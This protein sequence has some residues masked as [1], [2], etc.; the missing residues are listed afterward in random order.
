VI[1]GVA[2]L[3]SL[4][5]GAWFQS[6]ADGDCGGEPNRSSCA[7]DKTSKER[8]WPVY[9]PVAGP[10]IAMGTGSRDAGV[11]GTWA[12]F[13]AAE[14]AG[15]IMVIG[16]IVSPKAD[17]VRDIAVTSSVRFVPMVRQGAAVALIVGDL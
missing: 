11:V 7:G 12:A 15:A 17:I 6:L 10:F 13:G 1:F 16:G 14:L 9:I 8:Y 5:T 4:A 2:Y 3:G